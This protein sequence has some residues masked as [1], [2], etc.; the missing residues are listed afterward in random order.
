M[1]MVCLLFYIDS[2]TYPEYLTENG[3]TE[4]LLIQSLV[5][6]HDEEPPTKWN[7]PDSCPASTFYSYLHPFLKSSEK[8]KHCSKTCIGQ[9]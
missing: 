3:L 5:P 9:L 4:E 1:H 7:I 6:L 2:P 8:T